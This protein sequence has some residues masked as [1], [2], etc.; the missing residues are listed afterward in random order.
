MTAASF[1]II[2]PWEERATLA[3]TWKT[4]PRSVRITAERPPRG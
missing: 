2:F 1:R 3:V 4:F